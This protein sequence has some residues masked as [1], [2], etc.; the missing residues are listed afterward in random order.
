MVQHKPCPS[1]AKPPDRRRFEFFLEGIEAAE[2]AF[3]VVRQFPGRH[4]AGFRGQK[5]PEQGMVGVA[6]AVVANGAADVRRDRIQV[7]DE[8]LDGFLFEVGLAGD[9]FVQVCHVGGVV[10]VVVNFHRLRVDER[11]KGVFRIRKRRKF[12]CHSSFS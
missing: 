11:F 1:A 7:A 4:A 12:V 5:L 3:D 10:F 6:A 9:G 8:L 2:C